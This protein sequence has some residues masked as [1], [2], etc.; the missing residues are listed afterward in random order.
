[1]VASN[2]VSYLYMHVCDNYYQ[3]IEWRLILVP[4]KNYIAQ[5]SPHKKKDPI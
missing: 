5:I 4:H 1:V 2:P 3:W